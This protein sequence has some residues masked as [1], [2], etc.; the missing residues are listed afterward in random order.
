MISL[1]TSHRINEKTRHSFP[2]K[3]TMV[4]VAGLSPFPDG[5]HQPVLLIDGEKI[6]V[7]FGIDASVHYRNPLAA[8]TNQ[9]KG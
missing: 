2:V 7:S 6:S 9:V 8:G 3:R 4:A 5:F 1:N